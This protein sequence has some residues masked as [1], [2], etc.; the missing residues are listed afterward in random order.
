MI[1]WNA[2]TLHQFRRE[3]AGD[4]IP[5]SYFVRFERPDSFP[6]NPRNRYKSKKPAALEFNRRQFERHVHIYENVPGYLRASVMKGPFVIVELESRN[7]HPA[8]TAELESEVFLFP[9]R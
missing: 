9:G 5:E 2:K 7:V 3:S 1:V 6:K 8:Q 4:D